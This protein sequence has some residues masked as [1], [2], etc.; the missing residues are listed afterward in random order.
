ML[1]CESCRRAAALAPRCS[2]LNMLENQGL[3]HA[4]VTL[5]WA[6]ALETREGGS[7]EW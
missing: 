2:V 5:T 6:L 7:S 4:L 3:P 1:E